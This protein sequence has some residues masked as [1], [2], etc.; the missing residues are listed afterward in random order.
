MQ[1]KKT[2]LLL[3]VLMLIAFAPSVMAKTYSVVVDDYWFA[4]EGNIK[5]ELET[6][7]REKFP[8][9]RIQYASD[10]S[11]NRGLDMILTRSDKVDVFMVHS[12]NGFLNQ[13]QEKGMFYDLSGIPAVQSQVSAM[14]EVFQSALC[15]EGHIA[16]YPMEIYIG[17]VQSWDIITAEQFGYPDL[18]KP[19]TLEDLYQLMELYGN[20]EETFDDRAA[21]L[22][23]NKYP[24][25]QLSMELY[26]SNMLSTQKHVSYDTP[27]FRALLHKAMQYQDHGWQGQTIKN[28]IMDSIS[29]MDAYN[30]LTSNP[31]RTKQHYLLKM[32]QNTQPHAGVSLSCVVINPFSQHTSEAEAIVSFLVS[33]QLQANKMLMVPDAQVPVINDNYLEEI[34]AKQ[35]E[36]KGIETAIQKAQDVEGAQLENLLRNLRQQLTNIENERKYLISQEK[37]DWYQMDIAPYLFLRGNTPYESKQWDENRSSLI[38]QLMGGALTEENFITEMENR[39]RLIRMEN[40]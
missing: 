10:M 16:A 28:R 19:D 32:D 40:Q 15:K 8:D 21:L 17:P 39:L 3:A 35:E 23:I 12:E 30:L 18:V 20:D 37:I 38:Y 25:L 29:Q 13:I 22:Y 5:S 2:L 24:L 11:E 6:A 27:E 14:Y 34:S 33:K 9:C 1:N 36:I 26:E 31:H 4:G 7:I